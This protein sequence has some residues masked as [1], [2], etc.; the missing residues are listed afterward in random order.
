MSK[1]WT[2]AEL[3][4]QSSIMR[5]YPLRP[6]QLRFPIVKGPSSMKK[7]FSPI[8]GFCKSRLYQSLSHEVN[9]SFYRSASS[10]LLA[11]SKP[12]VHGH[13]NDFTNGFDG[14]G[15]FKDTRI[16]SLLKERERQKLEAESRVRRAEE[17]EKFAAMQ[18][19]MLKEK[20]QRRND[21]RERR[22]MRFER[23]VNAAVLIQGQVRIVF[24]K[25]RVQ[26]RRNIRNG[27]L[28]ARVQRLVRRINECRSDKILLNQ[29][30]RKR[31]ATMIQCF[32][33]QKFARK[34]RQI[35]QSIRDEQNAEMY[36]IYR[37][38]RATDIQRLLRGRA[39]RKRAAKI[40]KKKGKS[41]RSSKKRR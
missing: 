14:S 15:M 25:A 22:R 41:K 21:R 36:E 33:R 34:R 8:K 16:D 17:K 40:K 19:Q 35:K 38:V 23:K 31:K 12:W 29:L 32:A 30:R 1:N 39:G 18:L 3:N 10:S 7:I 13:K 26:K 5:S 4:T 9:G 2:L 28:V 37:N 6:D 11:A 20:R 27:K 24:A